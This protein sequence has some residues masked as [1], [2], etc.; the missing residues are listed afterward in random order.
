MVF[1]SLLFVGFFAV[2]YTVYRLLGHRAQNVW[3]LA[4]SYYFYAVCDWRFSFL[5]AGSTLVSYGAAQGHLAPFIEAFPPAA[6]TQWAEALG[7]PTFIGSSGR[8]FPRAM[9]ASSR[10]PSAAHLAKTL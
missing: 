7:Q 9:K 4:A 5:L 3:L 8:V 10:E 6:L 2:V 1:N